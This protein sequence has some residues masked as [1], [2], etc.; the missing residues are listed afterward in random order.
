MAEHGRACGRQ[1][2][3]HDVHHDRY[4]GPVGSVM[5]GP[6]AMIVHGF[7][8]GS[9]V[10][11]VSM[12]ASST[13]GPMDASMVVSMGLSVDEAMTGPHPDPDFNP[14]AIQRCHGCAHEPVHGRSHDRPLV[15][16]SGVHGPVH[17]RSN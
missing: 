12:M 1:S 16:L 13:D 17:G 8:H 4:R 5:D 3:D 6:I 9:M 11:C 2:S 10:E 14:R 15:D 7:A